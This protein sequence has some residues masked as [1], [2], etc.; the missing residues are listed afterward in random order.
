MFQ[1]KIVF[2]INKLSTMYLLQYI[3]PSNNIT[4]ILQHD[5]SI[6]EIELHVIFL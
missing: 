2:Y 3:K 5:I 4:F 6:T 1:K